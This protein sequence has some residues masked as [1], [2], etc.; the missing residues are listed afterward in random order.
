MSCELFI[1]KCFF[2][3]QTHAIHFSAKVQILIGFLIKKD[4]DIHKEVYTEYIPVLEDFLTAIIDDKERNY[5]RIHDALKLLLEVDE[6]FVQ[7]I[8]TEKGKTLADFGLDGEEN[9]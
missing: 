2:L 7:K 1:S 5:W 4:L 8:L 3:I 9:D 6:P